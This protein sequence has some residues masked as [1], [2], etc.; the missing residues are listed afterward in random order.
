MPKTAS[1]FQTISSGLSGDIL[2]LTG[3]GGSDVRLEFLA[4]SNVSAE[5]N[6]EIE[7][8]G[9]ILISGALSGVSP[10]SDGDDGAFSV[11]QIGGFP[12]TNSTDQPNNLNVGYISDVVG[13]T[14]IVRKTSGVIGTMR[15]SMTVGR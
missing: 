13:K 11:S 2:T 6:I 14:I 4:P 5:P 1:G 3:S 12:G 9:D 10:A 7:V 8:D 15:Y